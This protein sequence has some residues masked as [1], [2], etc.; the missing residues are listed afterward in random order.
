MHCYGRC[1]GYYGHCCRRGIG[2]AAG[3]VYGYC[4]GER[5]RRNEE[6]GPLERGAGALLYEE[7]NKAC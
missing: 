6:Q 1:Y 5:Y 2:A 3:V 7:L 4:C